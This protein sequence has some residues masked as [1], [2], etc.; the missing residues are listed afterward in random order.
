VTFNNVTATG[1]NSFISTTTGSNYA[2]VA[3]GGTFL[4]QGNGQWSSTGAAAINGS[5]GSLTLPSA[6]AI[7][8]IQTSGGVNVGSTGG[9]NGAYQVNSST[10]INNSGQWIGGEVL[11]N[12]NVQTTG[13]YAVSGGYFGIDAT[14]GTISFGGCTLYFKSGLLYSKVGC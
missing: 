5:S 12:G 11:A 7:N 4:L 13:T 3:N 9:S 1:S 6:T 8:S 2:F 14:G 10:V